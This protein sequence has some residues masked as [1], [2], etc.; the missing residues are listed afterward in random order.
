VERIGRGHQRSVRVHRRVQQ[1]DDGHRIEDRDL[2]VAQESGVS[3]GESENRLSFFKDDVH[4]IRK[5][6]LISPVIKNNDSRKNGF[7]IV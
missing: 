1:E 6:Y 3:L 4:S 5:S 2:V 7:T